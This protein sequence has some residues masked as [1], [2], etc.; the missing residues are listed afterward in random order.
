[1]D[2]VMNRKWTNQAVCYDN[3]LLKTKALQFYV[4]TKKGTSSKWKVKLI[5]TPIL[6]NPYL[7]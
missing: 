2:C 7:P 6:I 3:P 4:K 5:K 1:M